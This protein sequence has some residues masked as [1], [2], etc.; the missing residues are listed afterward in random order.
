MPPPDGGHQYELYIGGRSFFSLPSAS[1]FLAMKRNESR[2]IVR[3]TPDKI[4]AQPTVSRPTLNRDGIEEVSAMTL[5]VDE[6][7]PEVPKDLHQRHD[8]SSCCTE[9]SE[10]ALRSDLYSSS[11]D[12]LRGEMISAVPEL[13]EM[14][15]RAIV[16]AYSEDHDSLGSSM[17]NDSYG[18]FATDDDLDPAETEADALCETYEWMKWTT[19]HE[20]STDIYDLK[21]D[22][23]RGQVESTV[24]HARHERL[25]PHAA[26]SIMIGI[27]AVLNFKLARRMQRS[28]VLLTG[29]RPDV[30]TKDVHHALS[31]F[32]QIETVCT[33][34]G[35]NGVGEWCEPGR[36]K[37]NVSSLLTFRV[38]A[39]L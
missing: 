8:L 17:A 9:D 20:A 5:D 27:A 25:S 26:S 11:L 28:T 30:T 21:L 7:F 3:V 15:S 29:M 34:R 39:F 24:A 6:Q 22:F 1:E 37:R 33:A 2:D 32:G 18:S 23:M 13:E 4:P 14:M 12:A 16:Y 19:L 31:R 36:M 38:P 10:D 35:D